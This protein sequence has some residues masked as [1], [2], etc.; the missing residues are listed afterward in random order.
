MNDDTNY[1]CNLRLEKGYA[2]RVFLVRL[3]VRRP[4]IL[5]FE[6]AKDSHEWPIHLE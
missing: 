4:S 1:Y 3:P 5:Y 2:S 6:R